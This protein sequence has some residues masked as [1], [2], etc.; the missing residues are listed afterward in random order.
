MQVA[1][2]GGCTCRDS[3]HVDKSKHMWSPRS[4]ANKTGRDVEARFHTTDTVTHMVN[5]KPLLLSVQDVYL[6]GGLE[7]GLS[8]LWLNMLLPKSSTAPV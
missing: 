4:S 3:M 7:L 5:V 1:A 8:K 2:G 6:L